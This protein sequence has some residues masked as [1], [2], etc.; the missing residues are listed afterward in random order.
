MPAVEASPDGHEGACPHPVPSSDLLRCARG[1][2]LQVAL[3]IHG[4]VSPCVPRAVTRRVVPAASFWC[5]LGFAPRT[6]SFQY[7]AHV[8]AAAVRT[9]G[10][11]SSRPTADI[12]PGWV[13]MARWTG[14][15]A[16]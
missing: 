2:I 6:R 5:G 15:L 13:T 11:V 4:W 9:S 7:S 8:G 12:D 16:R 3:L 10:A 1:A 14:A